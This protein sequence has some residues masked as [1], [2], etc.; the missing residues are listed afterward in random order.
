VSSRWKRR[1]GHVPRGGRAA[2]RRLHAHRPNNLT[3][4][5]DGDDI[6]GEAM[7][8]ALPSPLA[9][10]AP[11]PTNASPLRVSAAWP[12]GN[13]G[14]VP[15]RDGR[16]PQASRRAAG[17]WAVAP[18]DRGHDEAPEGDG[19]VRA[20]A[21]CGGSL[22]PSKRPR[23]TPP[24]A[25]SFETSAKSFTAVL[26]GPA[27]LLMRSARSR[28]REVRERTVGRCFTAAVAVLSSRILFPFTTGREHGPMRARPSA[29][30]SPRRGLKTPQ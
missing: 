13:L 22:T 5:S 8:F 26:G 10:S 18:G 12:P 29:T 25:L 23:A 4:K 9:S 2:P 3:I 1:R 17:E 24:I 30:E 15:Q 19:D 14:A 20:Q 21:P 28:L 7:V 27:V 16:R 6:A 11:P